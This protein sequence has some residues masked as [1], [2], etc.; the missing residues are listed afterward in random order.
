VT[1][2]DKNGTEIKSQV[3]WMPGTSN[4]QI[5]RDMKTNFDRYLIPKPKEDYQFT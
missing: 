5:L 1:L 2:T 3:S 4:M